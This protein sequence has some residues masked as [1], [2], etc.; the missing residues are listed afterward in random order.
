MSELSFFVENII[1][2]GRNGFAGMTGYMSFDIDREELIKKVT[3]NDAAKYVN[4][5][6]IKST[7]ILH[8]I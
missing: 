4:K 1:L 2:N 3:T 8:F 6:Y 7:Q 5:F